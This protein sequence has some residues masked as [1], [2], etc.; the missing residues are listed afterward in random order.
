MQLENVFYSSTQQHLQVSANHDAA[1][2]MPIYSTL[3]GSSVETPQYTYTIINNHN[4]KEQ[5]SSKGSTQ[6]TGY[7][8]ETPNHESQDL[9]PSVEVIP[10]YA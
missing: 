1:S 7:L 5:V 8:N 10:V 6:H 2:T 3:K 4:M 9:P